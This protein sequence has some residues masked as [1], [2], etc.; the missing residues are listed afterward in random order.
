M[1]LAGWETPFRIA[2]AG[3]LG[4]AAL[5]FFLRVSGKR[6]LSKL[7]AFDFVVTVAIGS[8]FATILLSQDTPIGKGIWG[9]LVLILLQHGVTWLSVRS[10][11]WLDLVKARPTLM[12]FQGRFLEENLLR[13][14][15]AKDDVHAVLRGNGHARF[16][17][18]YAV[19]LETDGSLSVIAEEPQ[20]PPSCLL[21]AGID[22]PPSARGRGAAGADPS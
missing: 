6:T 8:S 20:D 4:Y 12:L 22:L 5:V 10:T 2:T 21:Q 11:T 7:N 3:T 16:E 17:E 13:D 15:V 1:W 18:I 9:L 14:R 19:V